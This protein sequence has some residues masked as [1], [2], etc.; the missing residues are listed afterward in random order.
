MQHP[1][2]PSDGSRV[3]TIIEYHTKAISE[4][5]CPE[6]FNVS[7]ECCERSAGFA[8]DTDIQKMKAL[9]RQVSSNN[10]AVRQ[11]PT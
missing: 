3:F 6:D 7:G 11:F 1:V 10:L 8:C 2:S 4:G 9:L 5:G